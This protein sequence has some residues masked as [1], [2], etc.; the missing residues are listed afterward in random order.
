MK[1]SSTQ[2]VDVAA[3]NMNPKSQR[4]QSRFATDTKARRRPK[5]VC[6][7]IKTG[8]CRYKEYCIVC[9]LHYSLFLQLH[10]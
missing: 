7:L 1:M 2:Q 5:V 4:S 3:K 10:V 8:H 6:N 9:C